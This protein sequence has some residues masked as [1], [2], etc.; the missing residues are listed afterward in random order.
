[1]IKKGSRVNIEGI[2]LTITP[3]A[4]DMTVTR[5]TYNADGSPTGATETVTLTTDAEKAGYQIEQFLDS[6]NE[7]I[8]VSRAW[9]ATD[10]VWIYN[11]EE[12]AIV[13]GTIRTRA[14]TG[15]QIALYK[16]QSGLEYERYNYAYLNFIADSISSKITLKS[17]DGNTT[18]GTIEC[19]NGVPQANT[20]AS[21]ARTST[22]QYNYTFNG[23]ATSMDATSGVAGS[24]FT[25]MTGVTADRIYYAA[26]TRQVRSYTITW[27]NADNNTL[28]TDTVQYGQTPRYTG[29]TPTFQG[30]TY[31][32]WSPAITTVT[33]NAT[34]TAQYKP[35]YTITFK[36]A[37]IDGGQTLQTL[38][39]VVEGTTPSYT[40]PTPTTTQG[41]DEEFTFMGWDPAIGP[42]AAN[43]T[44]TAVFRDNRS[45]T[46]KYLLGTLDEFESDTLTEVGDS[47]F[48]NQTKLTSFK[49]PATQIG[50]SAFN[51]CTNL[52][53]IIL[54]SA[55]TVATLENANALTGTKIATYNGAVYVDASLVEQYKAD[56]KWSNY[57]IL[58]ISAYPATGFDGTRLAFESWDNIIAA[59]NDGSYK[60]KYRIGD[61][62]ALDMGEY[63]THN[64]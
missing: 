44:Y 55:N 39:Y 40:G 52:V 54:T 12:T 24:S 63:G 47:A 43:T 53:A 1:M 28:A 37:A 9:N 27:K 51:G 18:I 25:G 19:I 14:L 26:Y 61:L 4:G 20:T 16:G 30:Q 36:T 32:G 60:D 64:M 2:D 31:T 42:A 3:Q 21:P 62:K 22:A 45:V 17:W 7:M 35:M 57:I 48:Q 23:W 8:G 46:L 34:Y 59:G 6:L 5:P 38:T 11:D 15:Q 29:T 13:S 33:G 58:P 49:A 10:E 41:N 56:A 50:A